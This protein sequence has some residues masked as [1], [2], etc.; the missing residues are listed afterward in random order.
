MSWVPEAGDLVKIL[1]GGRYYHPQT[2]LIMPAGELVSIIGSKLTGSTELV[3]FELSSIAMAVLGRRLNKHYHI[4]K[5][6]VE[7]VRKHDWWPAAGDTVQVISNSFGASSFSTTTPP[8]AT[9][10]VPGDTVVV[11]GGSQAQNYIY[12]ITGGSS[13]TGQTMDRSDVIPIAQPATA[14]GNP[15]SGKTFIAPP[16]ISIPGVTLPPTWIM[17]VGPRNSEPEKEAH[18]CTCDTQTVLLVTGC[19]CGAK[20]EYKHD[21]FV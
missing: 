13:N 19:R 10:L 6:N 16:A 4:Y 11:T 9:P 1:V 14:S 20:K 7:L 18:V 8:V 12:I 17:T 15:A 5:S 21:F 3:I 2:G